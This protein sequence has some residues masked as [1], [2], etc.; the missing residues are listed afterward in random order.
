MPIRNMWS[1]ECGEVLTA[2]AILDHVKGAEIYFPLHDIGTDLLVMMGCNHVSI[3]VKESRYFT[4]R[5]LK[6]TK[7][8]SWHQVHK[9]K[10]EKEKVDF[11]VFLTYLPRF[12]EHKM[13]SFENKFII[14]PTADLK[15]F[16]KNK[17][18]G[19]TGIYSFYFNFEGKK[20]VDKRDGITDYSNYLDGWKLI[21]EAL[22]WQECREIAR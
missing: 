9:K 16:A 15:K 20:V 7:G 19:Q 6:G 2:Q 12:G 11:Y 14:V 8:H 22:E 10:L 1:L 21:K 3:Q 4:Q 13:A 5:V 17:N 18:S